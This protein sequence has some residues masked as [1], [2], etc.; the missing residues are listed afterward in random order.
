MGSAILKGRNTTFAAAPASTLWYPLS[1]SQRWQ[2]VLEVGHV[3]MFSSE[4]DALCLQKKAL[5]KAIL[6]RK[7]DT[8]SRPQD[9]LP[10]ETRYGLQNFRDVA[11]AT[12]IAGRLRNRAVGADLAP[13]NLADCAGDGRSETG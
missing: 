7:R 11:G 10:R 3:D 8:A 9:P 1:L 6:P 4:A 2:F 13:G 12:R 5:L